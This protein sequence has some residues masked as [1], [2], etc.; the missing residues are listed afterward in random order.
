[1]IKWNVVLTRMSDWCWSAG[2][3]LRS[4]SINMLNAAEVAGFAE[5]IW[6]QKRNVNSEQKMVIVQCIKL[7]LE[8]VVE[9]R[10]N[11]ISAQMWSYLKKYKLLTYVYSF[12]LFGRK[13]Q[14]AVRKLEI[15]NILWNVPTV[16]PYYR[17]FAQKMVHIVCHYGILC[18]M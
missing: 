14:V 6:L 4:K 1:M 5:T 10:A 2:Y 12:F 15:V 9:E 18:V 8:R 11:R 7:N 3:R 16:S 13:P 17:R